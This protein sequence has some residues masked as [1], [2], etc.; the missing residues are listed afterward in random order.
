MKLPKDNNKITTSLM[1]FK[2]M[3]PGLTSIIITKQFN[4][5]QRHKSPYFLLPFPFFLSSITS[6]EPFLLGR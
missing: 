2:P 4:N 5:L 6:E 1:F 3:F